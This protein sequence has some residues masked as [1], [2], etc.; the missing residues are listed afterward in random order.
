MI[1]YPGYNPKNSRRL[2]SQNED[3]SITLGMEKKK[4]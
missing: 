1:D 3:V 4:K 2:I